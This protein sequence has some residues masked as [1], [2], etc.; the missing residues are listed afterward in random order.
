MN[1]IGVIYINNKINKILNYYYYY[2][3]RNK[4]EILY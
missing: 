2:Y 1:V 3:L 4:I